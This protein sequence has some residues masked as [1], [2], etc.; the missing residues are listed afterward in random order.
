MLPLVLVLTGV[1]AYVVHE[2]DAAQTRE[3]QRF[4][5]DLAALLERYLR[6][7]MDALT[8]VARSPAAA[9]PQRLAEFYAEG[10]AFAEVF[11]GT[12]LLT[13]HS[14]RMLFNTRV[15]L[16]TALPPV[17]R[18]RGFAAIP[19]VLAAG[20][21]AVGD[22]VMG[23][24]ANEPLVPIA[25]PVVRNGT[26]AA[27]LVVV[28]PA[29][30]IQ[31]FVEDRMAGTVWAAT[32]V[33]SSGNVIVSRK[34]AGPEGPFEAE[35]GATTVIPMS[36]SHWSL[37][38][39][40]P[41]ATYRSPARVAGAGFAA[42]IL[43]TMLIGFS[44]GYFGSARVARAVLAVFRHEKPGDGLEGISEFETLRKLLD[45]AAQ[46]HDHSNDAD[47]IARRFRDA[48]EHAGTGFALKTL[49]GRFVD[50]NPAYC[51][52]TG[53]ALEDL[54]QYYYSDLLHPDDRGENRRLT[55]RLRTEHGDDFVLENRYVRRDGTVVWVRKS[56]SLVR[57]ADRKPQWIVVLAEDVTAR[58][59]ADLERRRFSEA[60][61]QLGAP[62]LLI[63]KD[64]RIDF[65]NAAF[66]RLF[67]FSQEQVHGAS[68]SI[69]VADE[70]E[71]RVELETIASELLA[72][73]VVNRE[74]E[75]VALD[76][77]RI[78]VLLTSTALTNERGEFNGFVAC[79]ADLR[80]VREKDSMLRKL[81]Q[82][83]EQSTDSIM[84]T[85]LNAEIEYVNDGFTVHTGYKREEV[86]GRN[87]RLLH[88]G[89]TPPKTYSQLWA[90][91]KRGEGWEG[92]FHNRHKDGR[93]VIERATV[94]PLWQDGA[95]THYICV[96][97]DITERRRK[98]AVLELL[99]SLARTVNKAATV[100]EAMQECVRA[101]CDH[102]QW[103]LGHAAIFSDGVE[104]GVSKVTVWHSAEPERFEE[105][106]RWADRQQR[107]LPGGV[108][109]GKAVRNRAPVWIEQ[110]SDSLAAESRVNGGLL[111]RGTQL[112]LRSAF[113]IPVFVHVELAGFLEFFATDARLCDEDLLAAVDSVSGQIARLIERNRATAALEARVVQRTAELAAVNQELD[114]FS[115]TVAHDLRAPLRA[116]A[117]YTGMALEAGT[118]KL[119]ATVSAYLQS[120]VR[121]TAHMGQLIDDLLALARLSRQAIV[122]Q[123]LNLSQI[124][125]NVIDAIG[126]QAP[127]HKVE[128]VIAPDL[129]AKGDPALM[130][131]VLD[132]LLGNACKYSAKTT[133]P[134]IE[135]GCNVTGEQTVYFVR[136]NG[137][138]FDMQYAAK[139]FAP[140]QRMHGRDEFEGTGIG[141]ATVKRIVER[142][143]GKVWIDSAVNAGTT[144][145][146]TLGAASGLAA[147]DA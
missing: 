103:T 58:K 91:L 84:I 90:A 136:D 117:G 112:G 145:Y 131:V 105:F 135:F 57:R 77:T 72:G 119:D 122:P 22:V 76:G 47:R 138:G 68:T 49:E 142:H 143:G 127:G 61:R 73:G 24:L 110:L 35:P 33:D 60:L 4:A 40:A 16:E 44:G 34:P 62:L 115:Y 65:A 118:D 116:I 125:E 123:K 78:P 140:F 29:R 55:D 51:E 27:A 39:D 50:A 15:P 83:V 32:L 80:P 96:E 20:N 121:N 109:L 81:A 10:R 12:V 7:R 100:E 98:R 63:N 146:F 42:L 124:A 85:N 126:K 23:P 97:E 17:P 75:R 26:P 139:L 104:T 74:V 41:R 88:S 8:V 132:N 86:L 64:L 30:Q 13:D 70:P 6:F 137:A 128:I 107:S 48:F 133:H 130:R 93:I 45:D 102:G 59:L 99:E 38:I 46:A 67:G 113:V 52:M 69:L 89:D 43:A 120:I 28:V 114:A 101:I 106:M 31:R 2:I 82:A 66:T 54:K 5:H 71:A 14:G 134:R 9:D 94:T 56:T 1:A 108:F 129:Y 95:I 144:V 19:S 18:P 147:N 3:A 79:Y 92:E 111:Y 11:G 21:P 36:A 37:T 53:Y 25:V 87:P 141:L